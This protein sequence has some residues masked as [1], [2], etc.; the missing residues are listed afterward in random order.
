M[1]ARKTRNLALQKQQLSRNKGKLKK[2][3]NYSVKK[4]PYQSL[5]IL[6]ALSAALSGTLMWL[7]ISK[8]SSK[9]KSLLGFIPIRFKKD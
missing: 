6:V 3:Y 2:M 9:D 4:H 1:A 8:E 5:G 7:R